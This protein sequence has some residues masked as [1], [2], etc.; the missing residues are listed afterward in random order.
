M[1]LAPPRT[2]QVVLP[3]KREA[4]FQDFALLL[5]HRFFINFRINFWMDFGTIFVPKS[6][7]H[8]FQNLNKKCAFFQ[9]R[10]YQLLLDF[11]LHLGTH[12]PPKSLKIPRA[13]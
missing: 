9:P 11:G 6:L 2:L 7:Q 3:S 10:F 8:R 1:D 4:N 5:S 13:S 12:F